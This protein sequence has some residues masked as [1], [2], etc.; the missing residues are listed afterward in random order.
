M[1]TTPQF[2][3][4]NAWLDAF[5]AGVST[6][7]SRAATDS[8]D[9]AVRE[10]ARQFHRLARGADQLTPD[11]SRIAPWSDFIVSVDVAG[12]NMRRTSSS[13]AKV[14]S[15]GPTSDMAN[16]RGQRWHVAL[17]VTLAAVLIVAIGTGIWRVT[18]GTLD[19]NIGDDS[20][21]NRATGMAPETRVWTP[22][23]ADAT[24]DGDADRPLLPIADE[25]T[26]EPLTV[27]EV[28]WYIEDP[29][30]A[31]RSRTMEQPATPQVEAAST[32]APLVTSGIGDPVSIVEAFPPDPLAARSIPDF[33]P[34]PASPAQLAAIAEVQRMWM[35]CVLADSP[36]QRW[37]LESP[38][39]VAE[40]VQRLFPNFPSREDARRILEGVEVTGELNPSEDFWHTPS[41]SYQMIVSQG[42]PT[43]GNLV[44]VDRQ[45]ASSW[46]GDGRTFQ[47]GYITYDLNDGEAWGSSAFPATETP[48]VEVDLQPVFNICNHFEFTW[49]PERSQVLVSATPRCG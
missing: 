24:P 12:N 6:P 19:F 26:V 8:T 27:D 36:F 38:A 39:L 48:G 4:F 47:V 37:A 33:V 11:Y 2:N 35:A 46:T 22:E 13:P 10:A 5:V 29:G 25:C 21:G 40:Q 9:S 32:Q 30:A 18:D 44:L 15:F 49:F 42:Y 17:N 41:A 31:N 43:H 28:L 34:G 3:R 7:A 20:G 14:G 23:A 1:S 45:P 16:Y